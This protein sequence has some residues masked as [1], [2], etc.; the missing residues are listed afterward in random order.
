MN[1]LIRLYHTLIQLKTIQ[2]RYRLKYIFKRKFIEKNGYSIFNKLEKEYHKEELNI[3]KDLRFIIN[4]RKHY[5]NNLD[6]LLQNKFKFLNKQIDFRE[7]IEWH[8]GELNQGTRL[9]KLNLNYHEFLIDIGIKYKETNEQ[10]YLNYIEH[11]IKQW[12][13]Q[14]PLGT[15]NYGKDNWNSYAISLRLISWIKIYTLIG[16]NFHENFSKLFLK[17][18]WIQ[19]K[20][21]KENLEYDILG[22]HL[23]KNWKAL[24][25]CKYFFN[26]ELYNKTISS[27]NPYIYAQ[28]TENAMHKEFS[29]MYSGIVLEDLIE[30]CIF[31]KKNVKLES[32]IDGL[33]KNVSFLT[34]ENS[35]SF[36]NDSILNNGVQ[37]DDLN[38]LYQKVFPEKNIGFDGAFNID[39]FVGVK[40]KKDHIIFDC[41]KVIGGNQPGHLQCD[42][43]SFEYSYKG[44]KIF[45]N[46]G[47]YEYNLG[48]RRHY[49][50]ST[51][52]HNTLKYDVFDQSQIWSSFRVAKMADV[53]FQINELNTDKIDV[54]GEIRGFNFNKNIKHSRKLFKIKNKIII[55]DNLRV[56]RASSTSFRV[57]YHLHPDF[58]IKNNEILNKKSNQKIADV[59][60]KNKI[61]ILET[62]FYPEFGKCLK[63]E[64][65]VLEPNK[66]QTQIILELLFI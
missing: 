39:G 46:S 52:S 56:N 17:L 58:L 32:I 66:S 27:L 44:N 6:D 4:D 24:I 51:E 10:K 13:F 14:N 33:Y 18:L 49:S 55:T 42:A 48:S 30:V 26:T 45:T 11:T 15:K 63:K 65:L 9:W 28:F 53:T 1:K 12:S 8:L 23:I 29:P 36:F 57:F 54:L 60:T 22:N 34:F 31:D 20:F 3:S 40:R 35:Y 7:E 61:S 38:K 37:P 62:E 19:A 59:I 50:R 25:W 41:A 5:L 21:L 43:L 64:T 16:E 2:I 47:V